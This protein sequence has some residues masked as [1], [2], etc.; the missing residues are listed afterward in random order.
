MNP[1]YSGKAKDR[2]FSVAGRFP[3]LQGPKVGSTIIKISE[4]MNCEIFPLKTGF[5]GV[6][7]PFN[8]LR[9]KRIPF[10]LKTQVVPRSK[11]L[12]PRL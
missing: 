12:P 2:I 11:H 6:Q 5:H 9:T 8:H 7:V 3:L 4:H 10:Y 1:V